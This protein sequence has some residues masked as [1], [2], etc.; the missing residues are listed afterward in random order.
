MLTHRFLCAWMLLCL[1]LL[2]ACGNTP[3]PQ[4][5]ATRSPVPTLTATPS[6]SPTATLGPAPDHYNAHLLLQ[7]NLHPDDLAFDLQGRLLFS[8]ERNGTVSRLNADGTV[9]V[10]LQGLPG[11]EGLVVLSDG[12]MIIAEQTTHSIASLAP[13]ASTP[14]VIRKL[15]GTPS[16]ARCKD[17]VDGIGFDPTTNT[18]IIPD[19]PTG[20]VYRLSLDGQTLT[21]LASGLV[22]PVG[23]AVDGQGVIYVADECGGA[24]WKI[25]PA[26]EKTRIGG[27]GMLDDVAF[28]PQGDILVTDLQANIH[29][30]IRL[31]LRTG[32]HQTL[33]SDGFI[34]PQGLAVDTQ[35]N[36][37]V[38]DDVAD[39]IVEYTPG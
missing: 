14:V 18:L 29:A 8:D 35:G 13:G 10:L 16:T 20:E 15:P 26:G 25:T 31:N 33:A 11:P 12:T 4:G 27:F 34:E 6:P 28:D 30:L 17:G 9:T 38:S 24:L 21:L 2:T 3:N 19:S 5:A 22:R 32:Q 7:G 1:A 39:R 36:I 23:A 37:Y